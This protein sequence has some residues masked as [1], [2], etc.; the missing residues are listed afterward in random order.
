MP[1]EIIHSKYFTGGPGALEATFVHVGWSKEAE[2]VEMATIAPDG[3]VAAWDP[4][5]QTHIPVGGGQPGWFLQL[6]RPGINRLITVL[7]QARDDAY[8]RDA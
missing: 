2:H 5:T 3:Q 4:D 6:D 8:G 7:R 1:K